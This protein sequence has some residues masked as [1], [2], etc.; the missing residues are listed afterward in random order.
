MLARQRIHELVHEYGHDVLDHER[1]RIEK[2][3]YQHGAVTTFEHSVRVACLAVYFA[4]RLHLWRFVD[5]RSL[6]R[7]A[8][9]HDYFLYDW[10]HDDGGT[11]RLHGFTHPR[12]ALTN[13][14]EDFDLNPVERDSILRHM[15][16]LTPIPPRYVEGYLVTMADKISATRETFSMARFSK[17]ALAPVPERHA[18]TDGRGKTA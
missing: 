9:L 12:R 1:M 6:V 13:A 8:L 3:C 18:I 14:L 16:P 10:H 7:A 4:D 5:L 2:H 15:F 17:P 11:H